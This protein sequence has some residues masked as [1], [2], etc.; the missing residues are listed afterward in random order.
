MRDAEV[1]EK[2]EKPDFSKTWWRRLRLRH[3]NSLSIESKLVSEYEINAPARDFL[4][5]AGVVAIQMG[6]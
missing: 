4:G 3:P 2:Q 1:F 5:Y 6:V